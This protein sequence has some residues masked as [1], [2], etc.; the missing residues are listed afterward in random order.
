MKKFT[1]SI[2]LFLSLFL[3]SKES[4]AQLGIKAGLNFS[5]LQF[6]DDDFDD[7]NEEFITGYQIGLVYH[8]ALGDKLSFQPEAAF[9]TTGGR[10]SFGQF[11]EFED[12]Y[13]YVKLN[14]MLNFN[15][16]GNNDGLSLRLTGGVFGGYALSGTNSTTIAGTTLESDIDFDDEGF[17]RSNVGYIV[18]VGLKLNDFLLSLRASFGVTE[19]A[20]FD[21]AFGSGETS[22]KTREFS[23][24]GA[25]LF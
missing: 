18:G 4:N 17:D 23:L 20:S 13:N 9:Y 10:A 22:Y 14:A 6:F 24:V 1:I 3:I 21:A 5:S 25:Y 8:A 12:T 15:L 16:L 2:I 19:I 7:F 11:S